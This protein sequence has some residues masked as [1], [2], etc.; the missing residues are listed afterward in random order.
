MEGEKA[1]R[2]RGCS[3][4]NVGCIQKLGS[5]TKEEVPLGPGFSMLSLVSTSA[6][7]LLLPSLPGTRLDP[8]G[9]WHCKGG[10]AHR[11][12]ALAIPGKWVGRD[13]VNL[14]LT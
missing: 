8:L 2:A 1:M 4:E 3:C 6:S 13:H 11:E 14:N 5:Q 10:F 7:A 9:N 12:V